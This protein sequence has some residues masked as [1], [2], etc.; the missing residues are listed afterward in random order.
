MPNPTISEN[1]NRFN[2]EDPQEENAL[3]KISYA[4]SS[5]ERINIIKSLLTESKNLTTLSK[6]LDIPMTTLSRHVDVLADAKLI[7][8]NYQPGPKGH[9]KYCALAMLGYSVAFTPLHALTDA[10]PIYSVELPIGMFS[11][12]HIEAPC[13]MLSSEQKIADFDEPSNFFNPERSKAECL[14]FD[15]GFISYNFPTP[16]KTKSEEMTEI[17][18]SFEICSETNCYN[19]NWPSDITVEINKKEILTFTS[20]GDFGGRRGKYT[21]DFWPVTSTQFGLLKYI[22]VNAQGVFLDNQLVDKNI[23]FDDL[24]LFDGSS[25]QLSIGIKDTAKYKGGINLFGKNFGDFPQGIKMTLTSSPV[26]NND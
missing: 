17:T 26:K 12:C 18:F 14:W 8:L 4:L 9:T 22:T 15:K 21:P 5:Q 23:K 24:N 11:H 7:F 3:L 10:Q 16:P 2:I 25:I 1:K 6:E 20:P 13:G 19:N